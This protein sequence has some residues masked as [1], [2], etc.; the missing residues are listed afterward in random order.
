M[1]FI[2]PMNNDMMYIEWCVNDALHIIL[3]DCYG[4]SNQIV[5]KYVNVGFSIG[6]VEGYK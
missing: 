1:A 5:V 4:M 2:F 3:W 6:L